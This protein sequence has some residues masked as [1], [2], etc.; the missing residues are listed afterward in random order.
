M[1]GAETDG[2]GT[3]R[4]ASQLDGG[5]GS[6]EMGPGEI[7]NADGFPGNMGG[8]DGFPGKM[9]GADGFPRPLDGSSGFGRCVV[10]CDAAISACEKCG[11]WRGAL[12][13]LASMGRTPN[14][15]TFNAVSGHVVDG[16]FSHFFYFFIFYF[17]WGGGCFLEPTPKK[18]GGKKDADF[19]GFMLICTFSLRVGVTLK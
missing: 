1:E 18:G 13:V 7:G 10:A 12:A 4:D 11:Q 6:G 2:V 15:I 19:S 16:G 9:G 5:S 17:F 8:T 14:E 3:A